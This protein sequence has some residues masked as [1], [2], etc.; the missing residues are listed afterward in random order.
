MYFMLTLSAPLFSKNIS[1]N[2]LC[3]VV[4]DGLMERGTSAKA[5]AARNAQIVRQAEEDAERREEAA[6]KAAQK[7]Q[8]S[9]TMRG[10]SPQRGPGG[11]QQKGQKGGI[12]FMIKTHDSMHSWVSCLLRINQVIPC[13]HNGFHGVLHSL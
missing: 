11:G 5:R 6:Q 9:A 4:A 8:K 13:L 1:I 12:I 7:A 3:I 2:I 10:V